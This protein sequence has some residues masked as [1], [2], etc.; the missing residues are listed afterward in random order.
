MNNDSLWKAGEKLHSEALPLYQIRAALEG[1]TQEQ[2]RQLLSSRVFEEPRMRQAIDKACRYWIANGKWPQ[3]NQIQAIHVSNRIGEA[4]LVAGFL[5]HHGLRCPRKTENE[6]MAFLLID[7]WAA[8]GRKAE[9]ARLLKL[10]RP[11]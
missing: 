9:M 8:F 7:C 5:Y 3:M 6:V 1:N 10:S 11:N 2:K 4:I